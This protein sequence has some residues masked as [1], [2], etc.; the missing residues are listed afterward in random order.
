MFE[1]L[2]IRSEIYIDFILK[3][4][5]IDSY[6]LICP[7]CNNSL[8]TTSYRELEENINLYE[9]VH[10]HFKKHYNELME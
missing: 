1:D 4:I 5:G 9:I 2:E 3:E 7:I 8:Q 6:E 10:D